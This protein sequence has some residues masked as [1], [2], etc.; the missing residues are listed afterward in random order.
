MWLLVLLLAPAS[1][2]E[3]S[4]PASGGEPPDP[5]E[6]PFDIRA[7]SIE[8]ERGRSL[9]VARGNVRITQPGR[10]LAADWVAFNNET[11]QGVAAG[12][13]V[14]RQGGDTLRAETIHFE[15]D[16]VQGVVWEGRLDARESDFRMSG[17]EIRKTGEE[18]YS[19]R[20]ATFT[21]CRC[22]EEDMRDPWVVKAEDAQLEV[23]GYASA[24]NSTFEVLGVPLFW[25]PWMRY[26][27]RTERETGFLLPTLNASSRS[28]SDVGLPFFW[29]ARHNVNVTLTPSYLSRRGF[30]PSAEIEYVFGE[31]A[32]GRL[33]G[34]FIQDQQVEP[35]DPSTPF[36]RSRWGFRWMH[37]QPLPSGWR[38]KA[39]VPLFSDNL[40]PFD[41]QDLDEFQQD[42]FVESTAFV[43]KSF[44]ELG[45]YGLAAGAR[46]AD[47]LQNPDDLDRDPFLLQ[48]GPEAELKGLPRS[49]GPLRFLKGSFDLQYAHFFPVNDPEDV[50]PGAPVVGD[51]LFLDTGIDAIPTGEERGPSGAVVPGDASGD[52]F[53]GPEGDG[54]FQEG[55]PLA[56]RGHRL[57]ANPRLSAPFRIADVVEVLPEL[58]YHATAY[59]TEA[60]SSA[61]R[62]LF[63]GLL[64]VRTRLR[65]KLDLP[66]LGETAHLLEPR[67]VWSG[68]SS[69]S[70]EGE[71]LFVPETAVPQERLRQLSLRNVTRDPADRIGARNTVTL[72]LGNTFYRYPEEGGPRLVGDVTVSGQYA[73]GNDELESLFLDGTLYPWKRVRTR[74]NFGYDPDE[75]E[76]GEAFLEAR[77]SSPEGH[78]LSVG[79]R[80]LDEIPRFFESFRFDD[81]RF[82]E[83]EE[84][85]QS[86]DQVR[87]FARA[88]LTEQWALTYTGSFSFESSL[89]LANQGGVEYISRCECW[90]VR[91]TVENDRASGIEFGLQYRI[92]GLGDD[93]V[94]PFQDR[95]ARG[96]GAGRL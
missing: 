3:A 44:G 47:D 29:A 82:E 76:I 85:F 75:G 49:L 57:L 11:R 74:F 32:H 22:P 78:D 40:Y 56:D 63:T 26:P 77:W 1:A 18:T 52:D 55:E 53:P 34:S 25:L 8:Y 42:R 93:T 35:D 87:V 5:E 15:V 12:N 61:M 46:W 64:D 80:Y 43:E 59:Q 19:F 41:F 30:K 17:D 51:D 96:V 50:Y 81:E 54:V 36:D 48:R 91:A 31:E 71:P 89:L 37:D 6:A 90:A 86:I 33:Y 2:Q 27:I 4:D 95:S 79:Y 67:I 24:R 14:L 62:H 38:L 28:G 9:Y 94:R 39:D 65:R 88:A 20:G 73:I 7:D 70:Q 92:L 45:G 84:G 58:G 72:A 68:V 60:Q 16:T 69:A 13:V 21:T 66:G 83:F 10:S 23:G